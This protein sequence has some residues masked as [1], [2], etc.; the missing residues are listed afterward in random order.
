MDLNSNAWRELV[1]EGKNKEYGA[2][3]LRKTSS[4][5]H[6]R[7]LIIVVTGTICVLTISLFYIK[8]TTKTDVI[9][10][11]PV[12]LSNLTTVEYVYLENQIEPPT[13]KEPSEEK[14]SQTPP[15]IVTDEEIPESPDET[16][17]PDMPIDSVDRISTDTFSAISKELKHKLENIK[18]GEEV[19]IYNLDQT[20]P[21]QEFKSLQTAIFRYVYLNIKYPDVA[22]KQRIQG[23]VVYSFILNKDGS[24]SDIKLVKGVYIF[25]DE[26]VLRVIKS[27]PAWE[28]VKKDGK[29]IKAKL[30]LPVVFSM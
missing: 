2:Y 14:A 11:N 22:Y 8:H 24:I 12:N 17:D 23:R 25:L 27:M 20:N 29:P 15:E 26:E 28:P 1:F 18:N 10:V 9:E 16:G 21:D 4:K 30:Y 5:R 19:A 3:Y 6:L 7:A 13:T